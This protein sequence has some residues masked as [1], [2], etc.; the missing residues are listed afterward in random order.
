MTGIPMCGR[1]LRLLGMTIST[2]PARPIRPAA[3]SD[4]DHIA[5]ILATAF[6]PDPVFAWCLPDPARRATV[7]PGF[8]GL[9]A[10]A[11]LAHRQV[12]LTSG[13]AALW[14]PP[15]VPPIAE[16]DASVF[17]ERLAQLVGQDAE[18]TFAIVELLGAHHP[19]EPH[20]YL[21]FLGVRP[22]AQGQGVGSALLTWTLAAADVEGQPAYLEATSPHNR[23]LYQRHGFEVM[24]E[25]SVDGCPPLWPMWRSP[26]R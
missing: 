8:F 15:G 26:S 13:G 18:R 4:V 10:E 7:L 16:A 6:F 11:L 17:E 24:D 19:V 2:T 14:V 5:S 20:H 9:V 23:R 1:F 25:I 22:E 3:R 21:W 12:H